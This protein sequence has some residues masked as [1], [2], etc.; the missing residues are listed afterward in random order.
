MVDRWGIF[1]YCR[2]M[3]KR[4]QLVEDDVERLRTLGRRLRV[5]RLRRNLSQAEMATRAGVTRKTFAALEAGDGGVS[6]GCLMKTLAILGFADRL[7]SLA[8]ADPVGTDL[9]ADTGRRRA[10]ADADVED[11]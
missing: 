6:L 1:G 8:D 5:A 11:F 7:A 4:V 2:R 10:G 9:E 3:R